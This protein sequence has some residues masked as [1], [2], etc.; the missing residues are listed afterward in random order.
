MIFLDPAIRLKRYFFGF[1]VDNITPQ[2][3]VLRW[4]SSSK[5]PQEL[6]VP[7]RSNR[8]FDGSMMSSMQPDQVLV[9]GF[10]V[11]KNER[12]LLDGQDEVIVTPSRERRRTFIVVG[13]PRK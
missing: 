2:D 13:A 4:N 6:L 7:A 12:I 3:A 9:H 8:A 5:G 1:D 10:R 11:S